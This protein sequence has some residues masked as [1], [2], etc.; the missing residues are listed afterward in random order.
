[1][2]RERGFLV[3]LAAGSMLLGL[4]GTSSAIIGDDGYSYTQPAAELVLPFDVSVDDRESF[5]IVSNISGTSTK[6]DGT[7]AAVST[8]WTFWSETC[9]EL[10]NFNICLTLNDTVVVDPRDM[11]AIDRDNN[12][13]GP[14][15]DL[16][17]ESGIVTVVAFET[18][19]DCAEFRQTGGILKDGAIV[20]AFTLAFTGAGYS[21]G[22]DAL[23]LG[24]DNPVNPTRVVVPPPSD[25][26]VSRFDIQLF[27]PNTVDVSEVF[28]THL[29][30]QSTG[31]VVPD[32]GT[33]RFATHFIDNLEVPTSLPDTD[34]G[35][36]LV[37]DIQPGLIPDTITVDSSGIVRLIPTSGLGDDDY[38]WGVVGEAIGTFGSSSSV[39]AHYVEGSA[40]KAFLETNAQLTD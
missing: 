14:I 15:I 31:P 27:N 21:F 10:A 29:E 23:G 13:V 40:A 4:S 5:L 28:L 20:G 9:N 6:I 37:T 38:L 16:T 22:N 18:N 19:D 11:Q 24:T 34:V 32:N 35:C 12:R 1:V 33:L 30:E 3:A 25:Q 8:H 7:V 39:K 2:K 26:A 36:V 17:G